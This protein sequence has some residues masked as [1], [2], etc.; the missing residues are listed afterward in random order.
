VLLTDPPA[1]KRP[2]G[3]DA[4]QAEVDFALQSIRGGAEVLEV[5][6][7]YSSLLVQE[8]FGSYRSTS[9]DCVVRVVKFDLHCIMLMKRRSRSSVSP[10]DVYLITLLRYVGKFSAFFECNSIPKKAPTLWI[11]C[12]FAF[13]YLGPALLHHLPLPLPPLRLK[14]RCFNTKYRCIRADP[15]VRCEPIRSP[16]TNAFV[17]HRRAIASSIHDYAPPTNL[18]CITYERC[19]SRTTLVGYCGATLRVDVV[20]PRFY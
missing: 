13:G 1:R 17:D 14:P 19:S 9:D 15:L 12:H 4:Q 18:P 7:D 3:G 20:L 11:W 8:Q 2:L 5:L 6:E 10:T 16:Y